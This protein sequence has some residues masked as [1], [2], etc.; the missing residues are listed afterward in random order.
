LRLDGDREAVIGVLWGRGVPDEAAC[1]RPA[2]RP[3]ADHG[4]YTPTFRA[5][6]PDTQATDLGAWLTALVPEATLTLE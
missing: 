2:P 4:A 3:P 5:P 1:G 6:V